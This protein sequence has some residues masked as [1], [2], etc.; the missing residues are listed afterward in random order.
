MMVVFGVS[1]R[2]AT[3]ER[4]KHVATIMLLSGGDMGLDLGS[5][6]EGRHE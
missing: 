1:R 4:L 6:G 3:G 5:V 2:N